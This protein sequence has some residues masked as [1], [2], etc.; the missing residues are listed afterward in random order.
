MV[1]SRQARRSTMFCCGHTM[2]DIRV[3]SY[4]A[5]DPEARSLGQ[6]WRSASV[7]RKPPRLA[8]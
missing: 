8:R 4:A 7:P 1:S 3:A 5:A 6:G 2:I